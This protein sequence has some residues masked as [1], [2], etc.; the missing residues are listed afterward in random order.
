MKILFIINYPSWR[1]I[2]E[3]VMPSQHLFG[4]SELIERFVSKDTA[5]LKNNLGIVD[6]VC[7]NKTSLR[8][9]LLLY[10]KSFKYDI[11]YD[12][13]CSV[14]KYFGVLNKHHLFPSRLVTIYHHPPFR[15]IMTYAK[16]DM[17]IFFTENL[18]CEARKYVMDGRVMTA[19]EWYPDIEW[20]Q[21]NGESLNKKKMYDFIDNGKTLRDHDKFIISMK[22]L[23]DYK[24]L[25]VTDNSH[26]P[27][28][29]ESGNNVDLYFQDKPNDKNM[30]SILLKSR[31]MVIPLIGGGEK[32]LGP[33]GN[34]SYMDALALGMPVVAPSNAAFAQE[35]SDNNLGVLYDLSKD[36]FSTE[37]MQ[38]IDNYDVLSDNVKKFVSK[39]NIKEYSD[40]LK[41]IL[42]D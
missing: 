6:F 24:G 30:L 16:S 26:I 34:T 18:L 28:K 21:K 14:S 13:I 23:K 19:N 27:E 2:Q 15:K 32:L 41:H 5:V 8:D 22:K 25:I 7:L 17:S 40:K 3:G 1:R 39:H 11:I 38:A 9:L 36:D 4:F 29:Y 33:I 31:V 10:I 20:Y 12:S 35:I 37:L 42:F